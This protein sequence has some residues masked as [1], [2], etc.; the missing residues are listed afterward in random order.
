V[1]NANDEASVTQ[2]LTL[3]NGKIFSQLMNPYSMIARNLNRAREQGGGDAVIDT[4][5]LTLL[6]RRATAEEKAILREV[7][8]NADATDRGD[9]LWTV[10]NTRQ[11]FFVE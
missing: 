2:A 6:S 8:D 4:V 7:A 9:V 5:Y 11:F 10:L 1:E 3:M